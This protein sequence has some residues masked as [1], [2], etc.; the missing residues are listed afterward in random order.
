MSSPPPGRLCSPAYIKVN[1]ST[2]SP[3]LLRNKDENLSSDWKC[4][5]DSLLNEIL[6]LFLLGDEDE[7]RREL[8]PQLAPAGQED[9]GGVGKI[10]V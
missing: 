1:V 8:V 4:R 3:L 5:P 6:E 7:L 9:V 10:Q 2:P